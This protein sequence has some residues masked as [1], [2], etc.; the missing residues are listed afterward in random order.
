MRRVVSIVLFV[1]GAW[2]LSSAGM[3]AWLD[4]HAGLGAQLG[5]VGV[6]AAF[7]AP[8]LLLGTWASPG[9]RPAEL[10]LTLMITAGVSAGMALTMFLVMHD[11]SVRQFMP[12]DKPMPDFAMAPVSGVLT[13]LAIGGGGYLLRRWGMARGSRE[14]HLER[15]F[16]DD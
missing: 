2:F 16:G 7:C 3:M 8:F 6:M 1:L 13:L 9:N 4:F 11:P 10:G 12:P 5:V 14:R 15:V